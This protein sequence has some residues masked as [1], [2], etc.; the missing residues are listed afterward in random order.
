MQKRIPAKRLSENQV[1]INK[2]EK[3][4][5]E[6]Q[7]D[8]KE[9]LNVSAVVKISLIGYVATARIVPYNGTIWS[10]WA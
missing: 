1:G 4:R 3:H 8:I 7:Q 6:I 9:H 2:Q 10:A 5:Q